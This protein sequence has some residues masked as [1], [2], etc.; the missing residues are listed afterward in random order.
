MREMRCLLLLLL[1][2]YSVGCVV[3]FGFAATMFVWCQLGHTLLKGARR[4]P[5]NVV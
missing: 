3:V 5:V 2:L 4:S 1:H